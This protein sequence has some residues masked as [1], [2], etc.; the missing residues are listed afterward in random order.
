MDSVGSL[1]P[2]KHIIQAVVAALT[3]QL[4]DIDG[5]DHLIDF[6]SELDS[7]ANMVV[8][9]KECFIF[10]STG[11][12]CNVLP[13]NEELGIASDV[14]IVDAALA[15]DCPFTNETYILI[16][17]N[18]LY[19]ASMNHNLI[20]PFIMREGGVTVNDIPKTHCTYPSIEDHCIS[21]KD[22]DLRIIL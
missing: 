17:R 11:K 13:F 14:P 20:P 10:E 21:F 2:N 19:I 8:L 22:T 9:G 3:A 4:S 5:I 15:Y 6:K 18:A 7:H 16:I 12:T 1:N